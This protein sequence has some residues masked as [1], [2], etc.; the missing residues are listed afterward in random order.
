MIV[1]LHVAKH[2][3]TWIRKIPCSCRYVQRCTDDFTALSAVMPSTNAKLSSFNGSV[4]LPYDIVRKYTHCSLYPFHT[5]FASSPQNRRR[6]LSCGAGS[7]N[8]VDSHVGKDLID[9]SSS[10]SV[11]IVHLHPPLFH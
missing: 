11:D 6:S 2:V 5:E 8:K 1:L 10:S 9:C 4:Q 7:K 3:L